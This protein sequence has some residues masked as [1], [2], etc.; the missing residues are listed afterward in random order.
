LDGEREL[1]RIIWYLATVKKEIREKK[2]SE[3]VANKAWKLRSK[4]T[5]GER[6]GCEE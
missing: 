2:D 1:V 4:L 3:E 5:G 6:T